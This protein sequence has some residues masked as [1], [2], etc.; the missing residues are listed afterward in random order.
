MAF[1]PS[2]RHHHRSR[3]LSR[4]CSF[5]GLPSRDDEP[6]NH[7][8][9]HRRYSSFIPNISTSSEDLTFDTDMKIVPQRVLGLGKPDLP[10]KTLSSLS[11]SPPS[12]E[13]ERNETASETKM[14]PPNRG[15]SGSLREKLKGSFPGLRRMGSSVSL[16]STRSHCDIFSASPDATPLSTSPSSTTSI[17]RNSEPMTSPSRK[18]MEKSGKP[19]QGSKSSSDPPPRF[20]RPLYPPQLGASHMQP[21]NYT[22]F[23]KYVLVFARNTN[24][25]HLYKPCSHMRI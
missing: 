10:D 18:T 25:P 22:R 8:Q 19:R 4:V 20:L 12:T 6:E 9:R 16:L 24:V 14:P 3:P 17:L 21:F 2:A 23:E 1:P 11:S 15:R 13:L 7:T 5:F